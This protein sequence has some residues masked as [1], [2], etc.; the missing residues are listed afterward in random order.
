MSGPPL[1]GRVAIVTGAATGIGRAIATRLSNDGAAVIV[2]HLDTPDKADALVTAIEKSRGRA[3]AIQADISSREQ[4]AALFGEA[5]AQFEHVDILVNNAAVAP[6]IPVAEAT[7]EQIDAVIDVNLKGTLY[8][9]QLAAEQLADSGR[10]I[11]ISSSTTGLA[12][13]RYGIY[14]MTKGAIEQVTRILARELGARGITVNAV[15]PGATET[16]T[17]RIGKDPKFV[18]QLERMSV[19]NRLG[20]VQEIAAAVAFIAGD[21][22]A[23]ITGQN[24]RVNGGTV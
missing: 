12:L 6:L 1:D 21:D 5:T 20:Q 11:N 3:V 15:S 13:P 9:C 18:A 22:A 7:E 4:F 19:F 14:D 8:G 17:Y 10:I 24:L 16:E 23:W 2:N